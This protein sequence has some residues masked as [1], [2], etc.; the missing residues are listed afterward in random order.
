MECVQKAAD[1]AR[2]DG[3]GTHGLGHTYR[4]WLDSV[5]TSVGV[6]QKL[7]QHSDIRT[8]IKQYTHAGRSRPLASSAPSNSSH[9]KCVE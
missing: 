3:L 8:T 1:K 7:M 6:Q 2:I 9:L 4:P 5:G